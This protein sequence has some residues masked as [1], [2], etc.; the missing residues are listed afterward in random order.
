MTEKYVVT[1]DD[2]NTT[3]WYKPDGE[4]LH[5]L[6]G[7]AIEYADGSKAWWVNG[8]RHRTD[9]P[10]VDYAG[11]NK[12]W[13]VNGELHRT[14][15]PAVEYYSGYKAWYIDGVHLTEAEF[16]AKIRPVEE[17]TIAEI[18][19]RLGVTVKVIE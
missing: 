17:L 10:A 9:G 5:R 15:G 2:H 13:Y 12:A 7:P 4:T 19:Q 3:R 11:C 16:N 14:D 6:D 1:V 18:S 8:L